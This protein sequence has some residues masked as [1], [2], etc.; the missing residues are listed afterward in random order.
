MMSSLRTLTAAAT[1]AVL[2]FSSTAAAADSNEEAAAA[3]GGGGGGEEEAAAAAAS[4][5]APSPAPVS[6]GANVDIWWVMLS[7]NH[8]CSSEDIDIGE[9]ETVEEC[10]M[11]C[12]VFEGCQYFI[13][14]HGDKKNKCWY[15][16]TS[17]GCQHDGTLVEND[18]SLYQI[19]DA[20][21]NHEE[22]RTLDSEYYF[23]RMVVTESRS[24]KPN[25]SFCVEDIVF[26]DGNN[27]P[28]D[29]A[30]SECTVKE[31]MDGLSV[32]KPTRSCC[33]S[34]TAIT[35]HSCVQA[36]DSSNDQGWFCSNSGA[37]FIGY[38]FAEPTC[39]LRC[40]PA[41]VGFAKVFFVCQFATHCITS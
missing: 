37:G 7:R 38:Q 3:G 24:T 13:F 39:V 25:A 27:T 11:R 34:T 12:A 6:A 40:W 26:Y 10:A 30:G 28:I 4:S 2:F 29:T 32:G 20:D 19:K 15:E 41:G 23:Y 33:M 16:A 22:F 21:V 35:D 1:A 31:V 36:F 17:D 9:A 18:Y 8:E 14:G 5:K